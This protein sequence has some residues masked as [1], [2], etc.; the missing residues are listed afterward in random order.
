DPRAPGRPRAPLRARGAHRRLLRRHDGLVAPIARR[1]VGPTAGG[2]GGRGAPRPAS[3]PRLQAA[4]PAG[5]ARLTRRAGAA[6]VDA[7]GALV[8]RER[9][10]KLEV[11]LI[12][13]PRYDD[14][15]WP[16]GKLD[17]GESSPVAAVREV[18]EET[19]LQVALGVPLPMLR[20]QVSGGRTKEVYYWAASELEADS[21]AVAARPEVAQS[22]AEVDE[23]R[24]LRPEK[25]AALLTR[26]SDRKP[27]K[28][29][30]ELF[31]AGSLATA[32]VA[33]VRHARARGR[34]SWQGADAERPLTQVGRT[35]ADGLVPVLSAYG[36]TAIVTSP[37]ERCAATVAPF[38]KASGLVPEPV[39]ALTEDAYRDKPKGARRIAK[40]AFTGPGSIAL[41]THRPVLA[42]VLEILDELSP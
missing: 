42:G 14:W 37:W 34:S 27:L 9:K 5:Q 16:K 6:G 25:A 10:G 40:A 17:P 28:K 29:H 8:W 2:A 38:A 1:R 11:L 35:Q 41:C 12:Q 22:P 15:S 18:A 26:K 31:D 30:V 24:W 21:P 32:P 33:V 39:E 4:A 19:G 7:A 36:I 23:M 3:E 20:Y 13:R